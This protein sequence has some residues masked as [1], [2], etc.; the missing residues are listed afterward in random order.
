MLNP[1]SVRR[2]QNLAI[3]LGC[4]FIPPTKKL[5]GIDGPLNGIQE[6]GIAAP[7]Q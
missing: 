1:C 6:W 2:W 3:G 4:G 5:D 7:N